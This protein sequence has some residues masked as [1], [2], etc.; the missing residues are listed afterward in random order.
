MKTNCTGS[1]DKAIQLLNLHYRSFREAAEHAKETG[2]PVPCDTRGWSQILVSLLTGIPGRASKKGSDLID[3][4]EVK[5]AST[6]EAIDT[7]RFNGCIKCGTKAKTAGRVESLDNQP[8]LFF[9]LW[10]HA[11]KTKLARCRIWV[12]ATGRDRVFR[13]M[14]ENWYGKVKSGE[15]I[16]KNFQLHPPRG[17]D[18][19]EFRNK[20]GNLLYPLLLCAERTDTGYTVLHYDPEVLE[21]GECKPSGSRPV[22]LKISAAH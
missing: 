15:I 8:Y 13:A 20:S 9:A 21:N 14:A 17:K 18:S 4:S 12:V 7:P 16:S 5:A 10:D 2:H 11:P 6:W 3:G 1:L 19:D 22:Y